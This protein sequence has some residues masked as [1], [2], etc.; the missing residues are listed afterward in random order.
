[1]NSSHDIEPVTFGESGPL[2]EP[3]A[4]GCGGVTC[5]EK[6]GKGK[7]LYV[8][9]FGLNVCFLRWYFQIYEHVDIMALVIQY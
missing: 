6:M 7:M 9:A 3:S 8:N 5:E 1:M 2:Q 4:T